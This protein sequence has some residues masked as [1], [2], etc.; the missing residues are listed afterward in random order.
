MGKKKGRES[1]ERRE[2]GW[3]MPI[4]SRSMSEIS[5]EYFKR[6]KRTRAV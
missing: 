6:K 2:W 1:F 3:R 5:K 4:T